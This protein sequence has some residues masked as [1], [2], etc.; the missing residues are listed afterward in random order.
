M[1]LKNESNREIEEVV[2]VYISSPLAGTS[3]PLSTLV[4]FKRVKLATNSSEVV[5][6]SV[7]PDLIKVTQEDGT[8]KLIK[9]E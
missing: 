4:N 5:E 2:Q 1:E 6:F 9:G 3:A 7:D 8:S